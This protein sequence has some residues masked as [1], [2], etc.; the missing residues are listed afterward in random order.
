MD[1]SNF[2]NVSTGLFEL[3]REITH[4]PKA[5]S[6][7]KG[8]SRLASRVRGWANSVIGNTPQPD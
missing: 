5:G 3:D 1:I 4:D 8:N 2:R 6:V 7:A